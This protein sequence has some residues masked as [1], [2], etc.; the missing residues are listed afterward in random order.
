[1]GVGQF[2]FEW[3]GEVESVEVNCVVLVVDF[4]QID[5][6]ILGFVGVVVIGVLDGLGDVDFVV[7]GGLVD[8][9]C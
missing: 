8:L 4:L 2:C 1:M 5:V 9:C 3:V 7:G 6:V